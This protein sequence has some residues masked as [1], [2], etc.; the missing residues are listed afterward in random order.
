MSVIR[1]TGP[2]SFLIFSKLSS[3]KYKNPENRQVSLVK[4]RKENEII[5]EAIVI[6]FKCPH[7]YTGDD[8][9]EIICHGSPYIVREILSAAASAG[10]VQAAPGEFTLRAFIN[11]KMDLAEAEAV[12]ALIASDSAASRHAALTQLEGSL[13][14][15]I[16][17]M[18]DETLSLL[19]ETEARLDDS[20]GEI[21]PIDIDVFSS[22]IQNLIKRIN[23][24]S[25]GFKT[26]KNIREGIKA[27]LAGAPNS[28]K[29]SLMNLLL[30]YDRAIV[31]PEAGTT[32]DTLEAPAEINGIK[33]IITDTAGLSDAAGNVIEEEGMK[34][35][36]AALRHADIVLLLKDSSVPES[37]ADR[38]AAECVRKNMPAEAELFHV[39][40][41]IDISGA[42]NNSCR[43]NTYISCRS[44]AGTEELRRKITEK[45]A[46]GISCREMPSVLFIRHYEALMQA[47]S[48]LKK[49]TEIISSGKQTM[50]EIAA[51]HLRAALKAFGL[52][53]GETAADDVLAKIFS[54]FCVG[55]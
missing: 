11:G 9:V 24:L 28:G 51:E 45:T 13:S 33:F 35:A 23:E 12:N 17:S 54:G 25:E 18:K 3:A 10:A 5:D 32:R 31:S 27:V 55:K 42:V 15:I 4:I 43:E 53:T 34:R 21:F 7:S 49:L 52:V 22:R 1:M 19:A 14:D 41:K 36:E 8:T 48:E 26:G 39:F 38:L 44:G 16:S 29:S 50:L 46:A 20:D 2:D 40:T 47:S 30:G 37:P 6:F